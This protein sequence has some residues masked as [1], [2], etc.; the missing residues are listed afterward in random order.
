MKWL[1]HSREVT[2]ILEKNSYLKQGKNIK[3]FPTLLNYREILQQVSLMWSHWTAIG[4]AI[5]G[6]VTS[7]NLVKITTQEFLTGKISFELAACFK[8]G[9]QN[10]I[11]LLYLSGS[12]QWYH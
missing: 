8:L 9:R 1:C 7:V 11:I 3:H 5:H 10:S 6:K 12:V 4:R 2:S